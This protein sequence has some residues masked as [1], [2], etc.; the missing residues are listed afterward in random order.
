[1]S[2]LKEE[3]GLSQLCIFY[4]LVYFGTFIL[5]TIEISRGTSQVFVWFCSVEER[6]RMEK[7]LWMCSNL[8]LNVDEFVTGRL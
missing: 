6:S 2:E 8:D 7:S 4:I 1:M 3:V 5:S